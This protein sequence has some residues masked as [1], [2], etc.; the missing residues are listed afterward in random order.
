MIRGSLNEMLNLR[1]NCRE[2]G[3]TL[4]EV[5]ILLGL[6]GLVV[7][8]VVPMFSGRNL[9]SPNPPYLPNFYYDDYRNVV[10]TEVRKNVF[11]SYKGSQL[12]TI[13][14]AHQRVAVFKFASP[15][16]TQAGA[17]VS[18]ILALKLQRQGV[19][20]LERDNIG[21]ITQEQKI[22]AK[23]SELS[24]YYKGVGNLLAVDYLVIGAVTFYDASGH[25]LHLPMKIKESE[26]K[27]YSSEYA[28]YR[29]WYL[30]KWWPF[31]VQKEKREDILRVENKVLSLSE[32]EEEYKKYSKQ[33]F[34]VVAT[35]GMS[36]KVVRVRNGEIIWLGQGET[37]DVSLVGGASRIADQF[38][39]DF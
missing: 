34:R 27:K 39:S 20:V 32:L 2:H 31:W 3:L 19:D 37:N 23:D 6:I 14:D 22:A 5:L 36:V 12:K 35:V 24:S 33:E 26:R 11:K 18:D 13:L 7:F 21:K 4:V 15:A 25:V 17:L 38:I 8:V 16:N 9:F 29:E 28:K 10:I 30:E 1:P